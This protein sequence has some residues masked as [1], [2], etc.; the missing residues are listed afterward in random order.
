MKSRYFH[1]Y[2]DS[3]K[4]SLGYWTKIKSEHEY[5]HTVH[6]ARRVLYKFT[7]HTHPYA[8]KLMAELILN[9]IDGL[10]KLDTDVDLRRTYFM[11]DYGAS[12]P[13]PEIDPALLQ[14]SPVAVLALRKADSALEDEGL[15][16]DD[17]DFDYQAGAYAVYNWEVFY[18]LPFTIALNLGKN[19]RYAEAQRWFHHIFDPLDNSNPALGP[20][21]FWKFKPFRIDEVELIEEV[22][23]NLATGDNAVARDATVRAIGAWRDKPFRPHLVA[24]TRPTAYMYATVMA[25]LDNLIAWGDSLFRQDT[26]ESINE[27]MQI[28][29]L[30]ANILGPRPQAIPRRGSVKKQTYASLRNQLDEF[31]N[32]AVA[33]EAEI[34]FDLFPP[35]EATETKPEH[36]VLESVGRSLYFCIPRNEKYIGY[37]DTVGDRLFKIRN[38]LNLQGV[39]RQLPLFAPPID[40]AMLAR[41]IAAGVDIG[42]IIDGSAG[43]LSPVRFQFLLQKALEMAQEV[44]SLGGQILSALEKKDGETLSVL[45]ARHEVGMLGLVEAVKYAQWQEAIK[46]RE[47]IEANLQTAFQRFRHYDR[48]LGT[49]N[50]QIKLPDYPLFDRKLFEQR[51]STLVEPDVAA[52]DP[53]VQIGSSFRDGGHKVSDEEAHEIDLLEATE[54]VR[55]V[56]MAIQATGAFLSM[57][58]DA[59]AAAKPLGLGVGINFGGTQLGAF[60]R[61]LTDVANGVA[62]RLSHEANL[63]GKMGSYSRREQDWAFQRKLAACELTQIYKQYRSAELREY[64]AKREHEHHLTQIQQSK[65]VLEFLTNEQNLMSGDRRKTTTEEFYL[66]MKRE[67]QSLHAKCF[68]FA[69]DVAK[70]AENALQYEV[71]N[72]DLRFVQNS[73]LAGREGLFAGEKLYFDLKRLEMAYAEANTREYEITKHISLR[74][75]FPLKLIELRQ[76][77]R[78]EFEIAEALFDLDCPGHSFRRIKSVAV[79][80]PCVV[81]PYASVNCALVLTQ[82]YVRKGSGGYG[83]NPQDDTTNFIPYAAAVKTIITSGAQSDSG[84]FETNLRDERYLPFENAGAIS[85]WSLE[86]LGKPRPFD[87]DTIADV[88]ITVRYTARPEGSRASAEQAAENWLKNSSARVFSMRHEFGSEWAKFKQR[89]VSEDGKAHLKFNLGKEHFPYRLEKMTQP[90]KRIHIFFTGDASGDVELIHNNKAIGNSQLVNGAAFDQS[91][92]QPFGTFEIR[93]DSNAL[94]D[95]WLVVDWSEGAQ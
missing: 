78:S 42:A 26:R 94:D 65:D 30:A 8:Q 43:A 10:E 85:S 61:G 13:I 62:G 69:F 93:S 90:A 49:D 47:G 36:A 72:S 25:Y 67:A 23:F 41:A 87:Y 29:V 53:N 58:P 73:Y 1:G 21:R 57:I 45:R 92:F 28:Y 89:V 55:E 31:G 18:H 50:N 51:A 54:I 6:H 24:R 59:E 81:G 40:P 20:K 35:A 9:D 70:K 77:G 15:P 7:G 60:M 27:A 83:N 33:L 19:G 37:W 48:L 75:W 11:R 66:W 56:A 17:L 46:N 38:S 34:A 39:F 91:P 71:G 5:Q 16:V 44:K 3:Y 68:Q 63:A 52:D 4:A 2:I 12:S 80:I 79:S 86:L 74:D 64:I 95:L 32:A 76:S 22:M 14:N 88:I 84:L 82:S